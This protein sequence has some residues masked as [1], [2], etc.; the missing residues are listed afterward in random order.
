MK[1]LSRDQVYSKL[2]ILPENLS[3]RLTS[4]PP[5]GAVTGSNDGW[6]TE[7]KQKHNVDEEERMEEGRGEGRN[8]D[9]NEHEHTNNDD[10]MSDQAF[11]D[12]METMVE[13]K[14]VV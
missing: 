14:V 13:C 3:R 7:S 1:E 12:E 6:T 11:I 5:D 2:D 10:D 8:D 9:D 4:A